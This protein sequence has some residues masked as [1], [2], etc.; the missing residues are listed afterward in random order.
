MNF[1]LMIKNEKGEWVPVADV[2]SDIWDGL[3][4]DEGSPPT[5]KGILTTI[6]KGDTVLHTLSGHYYICE[7]AKQARWMNSSNFYIKVPSETVPASYHYK[8]AKK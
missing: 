1:W 6:N 4:R 3:E 2:T 7:N 5:I 8:N